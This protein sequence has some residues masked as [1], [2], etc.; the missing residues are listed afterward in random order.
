M[1]GLLPGN[2]AIVGAAFRGLVSGSF[3][4]FGWLA[5]ARRF[6]HILNAATHFEA[7]RGMLVVIMGDVMM[8]DIGWG[9]VS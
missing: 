8:G 5:V 6:F 1:L 2:S 3:S 7:H 9:G 4:M